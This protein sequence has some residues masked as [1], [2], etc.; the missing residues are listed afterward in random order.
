MTKALT[1]HMRLPGTRKLEGV[2][3]GRKK[4]EQP[5]CRS[6]CNPL[7]QLVRTHEERELDRARKATCRRMV[8]IRVEPFAVVIE[9]GDVLVAG[10]AKVRSLRTSLKQH[11]NHGR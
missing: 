4:G 9:V 8:H 6:G 5:K 7:R 10:T 3:A 11:H 1:Q 2:Q